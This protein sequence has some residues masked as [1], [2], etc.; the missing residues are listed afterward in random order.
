VN[1][2]V[3]TRWI[4]ASPSTVFAFFIDSERWTSWQ[5]VGGT[6]DARAGGTLHVI[7]PDAATASGE[8]IEVVPPRRIVFTWGWEGNG[9]PVPPGSSTVTI[10]LEPLDNGTLLRLT[11]AGLP[12]VDLRGL[13]QKGWE[14]YLDR[15]AHRATGDEDP[16]PDRYYT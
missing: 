13:H 1:E 16:G 15:L 10:E 6:I 11:H 2:V 8:F 9:I 12:G 4:A 14:R 3:V 7:M 5:G